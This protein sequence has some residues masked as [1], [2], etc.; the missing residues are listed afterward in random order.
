METKSRLVVALVWGWE[1]GGREELLMDMRSFFWGGCNVLKLVM[2]M[3][4]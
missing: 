4:A 3:V 1:T 2:V